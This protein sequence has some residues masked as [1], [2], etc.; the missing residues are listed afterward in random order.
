MKTKLFCVGASFNFVIEVPEEYEPHQ[1]AQDFVMEAL[2]DMM[3]LDFDL[4]CSEIKS[5][6]DLPYPWD[7]DCLPYGECE[8]ERRIGEILNAQ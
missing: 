7:R 1:D 4:Y 6:K 2:R 5:E 3:P 8:P